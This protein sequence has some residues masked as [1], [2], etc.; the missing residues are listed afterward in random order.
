MHW[1]QKYLDCFACTKGTSNRKFYVPLPMF[2]HKL[3]CAS[4]K[5]APWVIVVMIKS[6]THQ[7]FTIVLKIGQ[8]LLIQSSCPYFLT[9]TR[10]LI[11]RKRGIASLNYQFRIHYIHSF[12]L[13]KFHWSKGNKSHWIY[14]CVAP[15]LRASVTWF[16]ASFDVIILCL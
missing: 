9:K 8:D 5:D 14:Q 16:E 11:P 2:E 6:S 12:F 1:E 3:H 10:H 4:F 7:D 15:S 13:Q